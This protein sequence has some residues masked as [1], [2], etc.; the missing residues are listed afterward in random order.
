[1]FS[2]LP[3][4]AGALAGKMGGK[5]VGTP[6]RRCVELGDELWQMPEYKRYRELQGVDI[7]IEIFHKN[8]RA[9]NT[10]LTF[11]ASDKRAHHFFIVRNHDMLRKAG[12][13]VVFYLHNYVASALSLAEHSRNLYEGKLSELIQPFPGYEERKVRDFHDPL[14]RFILGLRQYCQH[15]QAPDIDCLVTY[16]GDHL[17]RKI[18]LPLRSLL[19]FTKWSSEAKAYLQTITDG[20]DIQQV[21]TIYHDRVM[22]FHRWVLERHEEIYAEDLKRF[23]DK[24]REVLLLQLESNIEHHL[25]AL[26]KGNTIMKS[27]DVFTHVLSSEDFIRLEKEPLTPQEQARLAITLYEQKLE[28]PLPDRLK[29]KIFR[30]YEQ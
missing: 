13:E 15:R 4:R 22:A 16:S 8:Y 11:L 6:N 29:E 25:L 20:V 2:P 12:K 3:E 27:L 10:T 18:R 30:L 26:S 1:L 9:L 7:S 14:A 21:A 17:I 24:E 19:T 28:I 23:R 5:N